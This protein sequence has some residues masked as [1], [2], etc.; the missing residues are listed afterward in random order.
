ME[1]YSKKRSILDKLI[2]QEKNYSKAPFV[3]DKIQ[4]PLEK[5]VKVQVLM[6]VWIENELIVKI[7]DYDNKYYKQKAKVTSI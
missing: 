2:Q 7:N 1:A 5:P 6:P 3:S 4:L